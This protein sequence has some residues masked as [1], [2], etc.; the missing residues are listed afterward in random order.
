MKDQ[1]NFFINLDIEDWYKRIKQNQHN[2]ESESVHKI[3][4]HIKTTIV[5]ANVYTFNFKKSFQLVSLWSSNLEPELGGILKKWHKLGTAPW[6]LIC[7]V[8]R[9]REFIKSYLPYYIRIF[10]K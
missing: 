7:Y 1:Y 8:I 5:I 10:K 3:L 6:P 2:K 4:N 9:I